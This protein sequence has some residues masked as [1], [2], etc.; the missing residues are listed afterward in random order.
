MNDRPAPPLRTHLPEEHRW[1]SAFYAALIRLGA[2]VWD[3]SLGDG[4]LQL[5]FGAPAPDRLRVRISPRRPDQRSFKEVG[6]FAV[7]Y[8][9]RRELGED[10]KRILEAVLRVLQKLEPRLPGGLPGAAAILRTP[11][12]PEDTLM[13]LFPF[14][15]VERST[16]GEEEE[17]E[18]LVRTLSGCNQRC[19]FCSGPKHDLPSTETVVACIEQTAELL[20][21]AMF[22]LTGG[23]PTLKPTFREE[24]LTA[25]EHPG[26]GRVQVQ[27]NAVRF[28]RDI[29]PAQIPASPKLS[30]FVS[31]H[32][33]SEEIYD[34][35]TGTEG[36]LLE[37]LEGI[38][39]LL[40]AGHQL[41]LNTV[42]SSLNLEH[43]P[44]LVAGLPGLEAA[45]RPTY[46]VSALI[47]PETN[48]DAAR[49]L[50]RY[51]EIV[52]KVNEALA[53]ARERGFE[54]TSLLSSTHATVPPCTLPEGSFLPADG[55]HM[56]AAVQQ[57]SGT[58]EEGRDWV[59]AETCG[60]CAANAACLGVPRAYARTFGLDELRPLDERGRRSVAG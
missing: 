5:A 1:L 7:A 27:T 2:E 31:L 11:G 13:R 32:G 15:T 44:V 56:S 34:A 38:S 18:V 29:D 51:S 26:I 21:G 40:D 16:A 30:F 10:G 54:V 19:P 6:R 50:V 4:H 8:E 24:L 20:P 12:T 14:V 33:L 17:A 37:A 25:L 43:L 28:A 35:C 46:H 53:L 47:C 3:A 48:P 57:E 41:I 45:V 52:P 9:G 39:R 60:G 23:E 55:R 42:V 59:K 49:Y 58:L 36:L 22:S